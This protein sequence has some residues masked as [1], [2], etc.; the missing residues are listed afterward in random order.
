[1]PPIALFLLCL[2]GLWPIQRPSWYLVPEVSPQSGE[3]HSSHHPPFDLWPL[4]RPPWSTESGSKGKPRQTEQWHTLLCFV[5][6]LATS[7]AFWSQNQAPEASLSLPDLFPIQRALRSLG[8]WDKS[9]EKRM[10][11]NNLRLLCLTS[12]LRQDND[13]YFSL[14]V[15]PDLWPLH[16]RGI[17]LSKSGSWKL[18]FDSY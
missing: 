2:H 10:T 4:Q 16:F 8:Y 15:L 13:T 3:W 5:W 18:T 17:L 12:G 11:L 1:M 14:S 7:G 9:L 6:P